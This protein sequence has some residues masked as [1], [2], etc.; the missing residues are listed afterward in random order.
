MRGLRLRDIDVSSGGLTV[1]GRN[2][3]RLRL[4]HVDDLSCQQTT[5]SEGVNDGNDLQNEYDK[6]EDN[7]EPEEGE[8]K[9]RSK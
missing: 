2:V 4:S 6:G 1:C 9:S 8:N 5:Q 3:R 7:T